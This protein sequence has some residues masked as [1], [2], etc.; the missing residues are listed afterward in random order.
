MHC[1]INNGGPSHH[2]DVRTMKQVTIAPM[3]MCQVN[4]NIPA[5]AIDGSVML[6][7]GP[8]PLGLYAV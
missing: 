7:P 1:P 8:G 4:M 2:L 3:A 6:E 5:S